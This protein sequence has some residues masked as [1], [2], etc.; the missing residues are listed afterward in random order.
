VC[1]GT[2]A[3]DAAIDAKP[4]DA[5]PDTP[6][7]TMVIVVGE[8]PE[9]VRD[10]EVHEGAPDDTHGEIDHTSVDSIE[11]TLLWFDLSDVPSTAK[12]VRAT[13]TVTT[14]A[15]DADR[16]GGTVTV[17]RMREVWLENEATWNQ[18][19]DGQPWLA[20]GAKPPSSDS[21]TLATIQPSELNAAFNVELP[22]PLVQEW[23]ADPTIN[24]GLAIVRGTSNQHVHFRSRESGA[25]WPVLTLLVER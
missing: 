5:A 17:H 11:T 10:T 15:F 22:E 13:L 14:D 23:I 20:A 9:S 4:L 7:G 6:P 18:R 3:I 1:G 25:M 24:F 21:Q 8:D 12:V 19:V 2:I 16:A